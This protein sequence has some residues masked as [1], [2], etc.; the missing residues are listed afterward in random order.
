MSTFSLVQSLCLVT[1]DV[2]DHVRVGVFATLTN[3]YALVATGGSMN[4][5]RFGTIY[6]SMET[7]KRV[8]RRADLGFRLVFSRLNW[9]T[10]FLYVIPQSQALGSSGG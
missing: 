4:F 5:Y 7:G 2:S 1:N 6:R 10:S 8:E 9:R 3:S